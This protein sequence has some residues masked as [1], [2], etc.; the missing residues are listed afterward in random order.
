M[1]ERKPAS[2]APRF[3]GV[4]DTL[5]A[6][7]AVIGRAPWL[8]LPPLLLNLV[9]WWAPPL[10]LGD[11]LVER[12]L[13]PFAAD[14]VYA[15]QL[16]AEMEPQL[17]TYYEL[18]SAQLHSLDVW[19]AVAWPVFFWPTLILGERGT[20]GLALESGTEVAGVVVALSVVGA[21]LSM[22][23]LALISTEVSLGK[24]SVARVVNR[25]VRTLLKVIG[26][27][28][29]LALVFLAVVSPLIIGVAFVSLLLPGLAGFLNGAV[30]VF[31]LWGVLWLGIHLYFVLG[32]M[33]LD[34]ASIIDATRRSILLVRRN[35]WSALTLIGLSW[36]LSNGFLLIWLR[37][38]ESAAGQLVSILGSAALGT[39]LAVAMMIYYK[40]RV[41]SVVPTAEAEKVPA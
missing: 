3:P 19:A 40:V 37:L 33:L 31:V 32:A 20:G 29:L 18:F 38:S 13:A 16:P 36:V 21:L 39:A 2:D 1:R 23:W 28:M 17:A 25:G 34:N 26:L 35:F 5:T 6:A 41:P 24:P 27:A 14:G 15:Q 12:L 8:L 22:L 9:L 4:I 30:G 7:L 11:D 10:R